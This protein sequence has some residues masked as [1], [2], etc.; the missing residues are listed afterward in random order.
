VIAAVGRDKRDAEIY[1]LNGEY[2]GRAVNQALASDDDRR[3][4][5]AQRSASRAARQSEMRIPM[6]EFEDAARA[7]GH[8]AN[9][10]ENDPR[11]IEAVVQRFRTRGSSGFN[12]PVDED[13]TA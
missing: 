1:R 3:E 12:R 5:M 8:P 9:A 11:I 6:R 10:A 7:A 4:V 13:G 2:F